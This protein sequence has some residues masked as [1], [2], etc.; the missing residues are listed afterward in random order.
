MTITIHTLT[1]HWRDGRTITTAYGSAEDYSAGLFAV[2]E[3]FSDGPLSATSPD[4]ALI[5][6]I[7]AY[8]HEV[9]ADTSEIEISSTVTALLAYIEQYSRETHA[10]D[11]PAS[12]VY[13]KDRGPCT[14]GRDAARALL[15]KGTR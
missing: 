13:T 6:L 4:D 9:T 12:A 8:G 5:E 7:A 11:C 15:G 3:E 14:C 2:A 1:I 10:D